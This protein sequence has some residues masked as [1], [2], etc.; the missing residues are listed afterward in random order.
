MN[1]EDKRKSPVSVSTLPNHFLVFYN[2]AFEARREGRDHTY[3][4]WQ[5]SNALLY[6]PLS[7]LPFFLFIFPDS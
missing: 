4:L 2:K 7:F 3:N 1:K 6:R 5:F